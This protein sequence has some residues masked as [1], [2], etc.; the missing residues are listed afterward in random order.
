MVRVFQP[1]SDEGSTG[2]DH[3]PSSNP[4]GKV[5]ND[6]LGAYLLGQVH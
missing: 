2:Y 4:R 6:N 5:K 3:D 1:G